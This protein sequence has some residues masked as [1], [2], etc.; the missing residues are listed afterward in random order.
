MR[1]ETDFVY[2]PAAVRFVHGQ[3]D[4]KPGKADAECRKGAY[5]HDGE[6][7]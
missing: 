7:Y 3:T 6:E 2:D 4:V 5:N 1:H